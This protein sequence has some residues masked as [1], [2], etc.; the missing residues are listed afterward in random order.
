[1]NMLSGLG[2]CNQSQT[3]TLLVTFWATVELFFKRW[4]HFH[5]GRGRSLLVYIL[6]TLAVFL[7]EG[8]FAMLHEFE[9][10]LIKF[11]K[12]VNC[13]SNRNS[14]RV[15]LFGDYWRINDLKSHSPQTWDVSMSIYWTFNLNT[16]LWFLKYKIFTC[17]AKFIP[18]YFVLLKK[19]LFPCLLLCVYACMCTQAHHMSECL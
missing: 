9:E 17:F 2:M 16:I 13:D 5:Q 12:E 19:H 15:V 7:L 1:M 18:K 11:D 14:I 4:A 3:V 6:P 8:Y 10:N